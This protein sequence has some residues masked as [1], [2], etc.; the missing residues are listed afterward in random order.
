[1]RRWEWT[2]LLGLVL[3]S[4]TMHLYP[5]TVHEVWGSDTGEYYRLTE[6]AEAHEPLAAIEPL[7]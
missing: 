2:A 3:L 6:E 5:L 7:K 4:M 1:M